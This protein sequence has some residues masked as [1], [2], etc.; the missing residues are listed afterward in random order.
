[1]SDFEMSAREELE[2]LGVPPA[3]IERVV[4]EQLGGFL[5]VANDVNQLSAQRPDLVANAPAVNQW[6]A[7]AA[8]AEV[9]ERINRVAAADLPSAIKLA[10]IEWQAAGGGG[11]PHY[12]APAPGPHSLARP[13][14]GTELAQARRMAEAEYHRNPNRETAEQLARLVIRS[15]PSV[16]SQVGE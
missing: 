15:D 10:A 9:R 8:P 2:S 14:R 7:E 3:A 12:N 6:L 4:A 13:S 1:M 11:G 5:K 16:Q